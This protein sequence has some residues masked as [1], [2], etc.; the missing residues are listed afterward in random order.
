MKGRYASAEETEEDS[1]SDDTRWR[2][3]GEKAMRREDYEDSPLC[4]RTEAVE[5]ADAS[6]LSAAFEARSEPAS[7]LETES[8]VVLA[9]SVLL[10]VAGCILFR[11]YWWDS[12]SEP[13][14]QPDWGQ[15]PIPWLGPMIAPLGLIASVVATGVEALRG[16]IYFRWLAAGVAMLMVMVVTPLLDHLLSGTR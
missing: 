8:A 9:I 7:R 2:R 6:D 11:R 15:C 13:P 14:C 4:E 3:G 10:L 5:A 1:W 16:R 12:P